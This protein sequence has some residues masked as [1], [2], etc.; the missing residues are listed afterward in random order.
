MKAISGIFSSWSH[1]FSH[2]CQPGASFVDEKS[3]SR[4]H[5]AHDNNVFN[6][7]HEEPTLMPP[8][9]LNPSRWHIPEEELKEE[10]APRKRRG[11]GWSSFSAR[12]R[13]LPSN[14]S[15]PR[16]PHISGP[17]NFRHL[18]S[19][20]FHFPKNG[21]SSHQLQARPISFRPLELN[22]HLSDTRLSPILPQFDY[23]SP[24]VTPPPRAFAISSPSDVSPTM[25]HQRS[26]SSMSFHIPRRPVVPGSVFDSPRSDHST[27]QRPQPAR[28][29][30]YTTT[31]TISGPIVEE[32]VERVAASILERDRLQE[33]IE[34]II[35]RQSIYISSRPSTAY[36]QPGPSSLNHSS[37]SLPQQYYL[38][39]ATEMEPMPEIPA[40]PPNAPSFSERVSS[41]RSPTTSTSATPLPQQQPPKP[42]LTSKTRTA[43]Q[44]NSSRKIEGRAPPPPLPLRLRP[45]LRKKKSFSRVSSWI[46]SGGN[47]E[48]HK[49]DISL[50]SLTNAPKPVT[51]S[52]GFYTVAHGRGSSQERSSFDSEST[53]SDWTV[54]EQTLPTS[55]SPSTPRAWTGTP[56]FGLREPVVRAVPQR[57]SVGVA[58]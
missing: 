20:S 32:L 3:Q 16:R 39:T 44:A 53:V 31:S 55:L 37:I 4:T 13:L 56:T 12:K 47:V 40:L 51:G 8:P 34:D 48:H 14:T 25:S 7:V 22:L 9:D 15:L 18:Y 42:I 21:S 10:L 30:G 23:P 6:V 45:P 36:G 43:Y 28:M 41:D 38:T 50:D 11:S 26:Y 54:E 27:P 57:T 17:S 33:Q 19:E 1:C 58:F 5:E 2:F 52:D 24:P 46:F 35:E 49:R 29:R